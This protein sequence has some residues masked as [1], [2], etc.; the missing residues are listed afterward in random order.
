MAE[1]T[2]ESSNRQHLETE[3]GQLRR[4]AQEQA[5]EGFV[6]VYRGETVDPDE[7]QIGPHQKVQ[8]GTWFT[9]NFGFA[10]Q[11][12]EKMRERGIEDTRIVAIA[13]PKS[14]LSR[15]EQIK[16]RGRMPI[17]GG[18]TIQVNFRPDLIERVVEKQI[19]DTPSTD[20]YVDQFRIVQ[21]LKPT[22]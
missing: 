9:P 8:A 12:A 20:T 17:G 6:W 15:E 5:E 11:H 21:E 16:Q 10:Q 22:T 18:D 19:A 1:D 13:I 4:Y 14:M 7:N 3:V 2:G